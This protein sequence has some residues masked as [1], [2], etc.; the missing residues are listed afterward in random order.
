[1]TLTVL[2]VLKC[3][4]S[5]TG[6]FQFGVFQ[7]VPN[8]RTSE[9]QITARVDGPN[10]AVPQQH[11]DCSWSGSPGID[12]SS[13]HDFTNHHEATGFVWTWTGKALGGRGGRLNI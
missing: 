8:N 9:T 5:G 1:M 7:D 3:N 6:V 10:S 13:P 4:L 2:N 11:V 12:S